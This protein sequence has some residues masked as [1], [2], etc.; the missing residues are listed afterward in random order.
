M[1]RWKIATKLHKEHHP[2]RKQFAFALAKRFD[3]LTNSNKAEV[4]YLRFRIRLSEKVWV[5]L[6][7]IYKSCLAAEPFERTSICERFVCQQEGNISKRE[8]TPRSRTYNYKISIHGNNIVEI[9]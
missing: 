9:V 7:E 1:K 5:D 3:R 4:D 2:T 6:K 8:R